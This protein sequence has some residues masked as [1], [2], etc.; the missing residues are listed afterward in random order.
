MDNKFLEEL[1][2]QND[3]IKG[4]FVFL[5]SKEGY[6]DSQIRGAIGKVDNNRI[7]KIRTGLKK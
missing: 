7:T 4:I 3:L 2:K 1:K 5:L 6:S